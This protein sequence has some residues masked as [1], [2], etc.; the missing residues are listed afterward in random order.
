MQGWQQG[1]D[2]LQCDT[3]GHWCGGGCRD[4]R[5]NQLAALP[6]SFANVWGNIITEEDYEQEEEEDNEEEDEDEDKDE[7]EQDPGV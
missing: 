7:E 3:D 5:H 6:E 2:G 1:C 4:L